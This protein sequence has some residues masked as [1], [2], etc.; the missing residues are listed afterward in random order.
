[1]KKTCVIDV[2][3]S[4]NT[5]VF[6]VPIRVLAVS[7]CITATEGEN[8]VLV[9]LDFTDEFT[10]VN[11]NSDQLPAEFRYVL[12]ERNYASSYCA[13]DMVVRTIKVRGNPSLAYGFFSILYELVES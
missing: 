6:P 3:T 2:Q 9:G 1:M 10:S 5:L 4:P 12:T 11:G 7:A 8:N 13:T